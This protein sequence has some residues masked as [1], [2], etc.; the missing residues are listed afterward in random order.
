VFLHLDSVSMVTKF[1]GFLPC[2]V[3]KQNDMKVL[4]FLKTFYRLH[5]L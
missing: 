3:L 1:C 4:Q 5:E 2:V